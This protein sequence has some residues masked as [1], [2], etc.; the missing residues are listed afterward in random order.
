M[1]VRFSKWIERSRSSPAST[2]LQE[3]DALILNREYTR[4]CERQVSFLM[5]MVTILTWS[6]DIYFDSPERN[7]PVKEDIKV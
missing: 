6:M 4:E 1:I 5:E 3:V 2:V 7:G